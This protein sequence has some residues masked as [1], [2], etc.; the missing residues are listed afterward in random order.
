[1][2]QP[3]P[4]TTEPII[5]PP[6]LPTRKFNP[7][8]VLAAVILLIIVGAG[9]IF[10]GK[11]LNNSQSSAQPTVA[12]VPDETANWKMYTNTKLGYSFTY[13]ISWANCPNNFGGGQTD[14]TA[15][16]CSASF[17]PFDYIW[18]SFINN[19]QNL[20]FQQLVTQNLNEDLKNSF[21]YTTIT[22][23]QN[24]A[25][26]T[27][28]LPGSTTSESVFFKTSNNGYIGI[29]YQP[30]DSGSGF[31]ETYS[32]YKIFDQILSTFKFLQ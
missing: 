29:S 10:L 1:M 30:V 28:S 20:N 27:K 17:Q 14:T 25:Y 31:S 3:P 11:S 22:I 4:I 13:P 15:Y 9:G 5:E 6:I 18:T 21:K 23:G 16:L 32:S 7:I 8:L 12:P 2:I 19:P 26:V 24:S